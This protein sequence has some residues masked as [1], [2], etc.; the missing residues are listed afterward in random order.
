MPTSDLRYVELCPGR[1]LHVRIKLRSH[2][3]DLF[4]LYQHPWRS[5]TTQEQNLE[6]RGR[7]WQ[8]LNESLI[9]VPCRNQLLVTGNFNISLRKDVPPDHGEFRILTYRFL[10]AGT[11]LTGHL[12][13][14]SRQC[15]LDSEAMELPHLRRGMDLMS[16]HLKLKLPLMPAETAD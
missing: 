13:F 10:S 2:S 15:Q 14:D 8:T 4:N 1:L 11:S 12:L 7:V 3:L 5:T 6:G 16:N 9:H